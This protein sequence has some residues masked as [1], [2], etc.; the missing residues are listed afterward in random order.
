MSDVVNMTKNAGVS[1]EKAMKVSLEKGNDPG[2]I[3]VNV[4]CYIDVSGSMYE[5]YQ[6]RG[7][8]PGVKGL[9]GKV[10]RQPTAGGPSEMQETVTRNL[11]LTLTGLDKDGTVPLKAF[12]HGLKDI[13]VVNDQNYEQV[14]T[15]WL[16]HT[17]IN[18]GTN[19]MP[20]MADVL[21]QTHDPACPT[22]VL[23]H[24]DGV[25]NDV[26][27]FTKAIVGCSGQPIFWIFVG[28]GVSL[29]FLR[30]LDTMEGR[31]VDNV[32]LTE[33]D[34]AGA[35]DDEMYYDALVHELIVDWYPAARAK[36]IIK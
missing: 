17:S 6:Q 9:F 2:N 28:H 1:L 35:W 32:S 25:P 33:L 11:A 13:G 36:G 12:D 5:R 23:I 14:L 34:D 31:V 29:E 15:D 30:K 3:E 16:A 19:Y 24:T 21:S 10:K 18:G 22:V 4:L 26:A 8:S 7:S 27:A 20:I